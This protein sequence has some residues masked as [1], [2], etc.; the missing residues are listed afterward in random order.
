M[1]TTNLLQSYINNNPRT[2]QYQS[3]KVSKDFDIHRELTNRTFI[4]PLPSNGKLL[5]PTIMDYP[6]EIQKDIK[7]DAK[8]LYHAIKGEANDHELGRLN[9]VGM[10]LGGLVLATY[11]FTKKQT[12]KTKLFEFIGFGTFFAAMDLWPKLFI[13]L[14]AKLI[15]GV[16]VRQ[17]YEDSFGRKK[18][19]YQ[20]H[21]FIPWDLY[22]DDEINKIGD[23]LGIPKDIPNRRNAIQEKMRQIALQNNTLWMLTAGF[24]TPLLSA[25]LCNAVDKTVNKITDQRMDKIADNL[26]KNFPKEIEKYDFSKGTAELET[27]LTK[28]AGKPLTK[29]V[30]QE[31]FSN[32]S[33]GLDKVVA[34]GLQSDLD[35]FL[36]TDKNYRISENGV[37]NI[38][39]TI[40]EILKPA[41]L[42]DEVLERIVP[43]AE[44]LSEQFTSRGLLNGTFEE[45]SEHSKIIQDVL[46]QNIENVSSELDDTAR[47]KL[48]FLSGKLIHSPKLNQDSPLIKTLK[49]EPAEILTSERIKV[50][51]SISENLNTFKAGSSILD[52]YSYIKVAQAPETGIANIWN[53]MQEE[54]F[55]AMHFS[56]DEVKLARLD[57]EAATEILRN[58]MENLVSNKAEYTKFI[59]KMESLLSTLH[60]RTKDIDM[61]QDKN[62]NLYKSS[63]NST[64]DNTSKTLLGYNMKHT[65]EAIGGIIDKNNNFISDRTSAKHLM[66]TYVEDRIK[67]VKSSFYRFLNF[68]D[69]YYRIAHIDG[70]TQVL[71]SRIPREIK[72]EMVELAKQIMIDGHTSDFAV[73]FWQLRNPEA[74]KK[75]YS[76]IVT[77]HGKVINKYLGV[78]EHE[79]VELSNDRHY[80]DS[81]MKLMYGEDVHPDTAARIEKSGFWSDFKKFRHDILEILGGDSYFA[82]PNH[83]VNSTPVKSSSE[84]KFILTGCVPSDMAHKAFNNMFNS[85]KW[86]SVFGK[87]GAGLIGVTLLTQ[88]IIGKNKTPWKNKENN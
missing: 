5:H 15:H 49:L 84:E 68:A 29:E 31:I 1:R 3:D 75:D 53:N 65:A 42:S 43:Q 51:K 86:F 74:N 18:M 20:D 80:F 36:P 73:K 81:V 60:S 23:R 34:D 33:N 8:A 14:P 7:Y 77:D 28:N 30:V 48:N 83:L 27:I 79:C 12:P 39:Q 66:L 24:A 57:N 52:R 46:A 59:D 40:R 35:L 69:L 41:N 88:F 6:A 26:L 13:Q 72:E 45:F 25:L 63:V 50:L 10:K 85:G 19:F 82:K 58:K 47:A 11:L 70:D 22:K 61:H 55:K 37:N 62:I 16:N 44:Q 21:Q 9:D 54:I 67:G 4:K 76:Q 17:E 87:L 32:I 64:C 71:N 78:G 56:Q 2:Q 38:K